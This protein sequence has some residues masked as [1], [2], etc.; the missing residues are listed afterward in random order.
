MKLSMN[1]GK[2]STLKGLPIVAAL[3]V[4]RWT[5][6]V[7]HRFRG[8]MREA[9]FRRILPMNLGQG[10]AALRAAR[11]RGTGAL[12][13]CLAWLV[14]LWLVGTSVSVSA[15]QAGP[16]TAPRVPERYLIVLDISSPMRNRAP[17]V[18]EAIAALL[19]SGMRGE[20]RDGDE[21]GVWTYNDA[22]HTGEFELL[23]WKEAQ[24]EA[25]ARRVREF[26]ERQRYG[27]NTDFSK[28]MPEL[29]TLVAESRRLT[30][31]VCADGDE[32]MLGTPFDEGLARSL[33]EH[34]TVLKGKRLP[35]F[36]VLRGQLGQ[37]V[38]YRISY[39]PW[40]VDFPPF[41]AE[42]KPE[43]VV[44]APTN[45]GLPTPDLLPPLLS[46][47]RGPIVFAEPLI[48][49]GKSNRPT[50]APVVVTNPV[51]A[52]PVAVETNL[53][54]GT[55]GE[56]APSAPL[57]DARSR[58]AEMAPEPQNRLDA[59]LPT[60][61]VEARTAY[62]RV[63]LVLAVGLGGLL[64][65]GGGLLL[66]RGRGKSHASLITRTMAPDDESGTPP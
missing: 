1:R 36:I 17:A 29:L 26:L 59:A 24:R 52:V 62:P 3:D 33:Q 11:R 28:V 43:P 54:T 63:F 19:A 53:P 32:V 15:A 64:A 5:L 49:S 39:P 35:L 41:P 58:P 38:G 55:V 4:E 40:P 2:H 60:G 66:L 46:S 25:I 23:E 14:G 45:A 10:R 13:G 44:T 30:V 47:N 31:M 65:A 6:D 50:L 56:I 37:L 21:L 7:L 22:L 57:A 20:I 18:Q 27:R 12:P 61:N 9:G 48:V 42:P 8:S 16:A 34:A 51:A